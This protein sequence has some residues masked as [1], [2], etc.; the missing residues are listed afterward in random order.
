MAPVVAPAVTPA[1]VGQTTVTGLISDP[2]GNPATGG[3]VTFVLSPS[4]SAIAFR[5]AGTSIFAPRAVVCQI[6]PTGQLL[7][8]QGTGPCL[9][10]GN[11]A[12]L[13]GNTTYT[14]LIAPTVNGSPLTTSTIYGVLIFGS[15]YD[16]SNI[17]FAPNI[18]ITP[19]QTVLRGDPVEANLIPITGHV[20]NIGSQQLPYAALY[21]DDL[22]V[23]AGGEI[24]ADNIEA[25]NIAADN[26]TTS[27][28]AATNISTSQIRA[29]TYLNLPP[30]SGT[31]TNLL[32]AFYVNACNFTGP[33]AGSIM[34]S[35]IA[36]IPASGG[37][38]DARCLS[39]NINVT[40]TVP[41][42]V[43]VLLGPSY[44]A[45]VQ[46]FSLVG[47]GAALVGFGSGQDGV[48][49]DI[50]PTAP[51][52][53]SASG[54]A[55]TVDMIRVA[56][57]NRSTGIGAKL[58][59]IVLK[60]FAID[61]AG[62]GRRAVYATTT[63]FSIFEDIKIWN[64]VE[65]GFRLEGRLSTDP[66]S[67]PAAYQN[68]LHLVQVQ[69][70]ASNNSGAG[71][72]LDATNGEIS[73]TMFLQCRSSGNISTGGGKQALLL[74]AGTAAN[75]S[76]THTD[77]DT[78]YFGNPVSVAGSYGIQMKAPGVFTSQTGG[79]VWN[80]NIRATLVERL[81][82]SALGVGIGATDG[83]NNPSG[84]GVGST[85]L[86]NTGVGANWATAID[87]RN[88][89][90]MSLVLPN[91]SLPTN[92]PAIWLPSSNAGNNASGMT[93]DG[94]YSGGSPMF[95]LLVSPSFSG[96]AVGYGI[97]CSAS[98]ATTSYGLRVAGGITRFDGNVG[99]GEDPGNSPLRI[100]TAVSGLNADFLRVDGIATSTAA[101]QDQFAL[102]IV[103]TFATA[104]LNPG[105]LRGIL[106]DVGGAI[107][108][109][110]TASA[111]I[112]GDFTGP[113]AGA[114]LMLGVR[115]N[116]GIQMVP[117]V[118]K[119]TASATYRG[120]FWVTQGAAGVKDNVEVCAKD[121]TDTYAW[122]TIY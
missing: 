113:T 97:F 24:V 83:S 95:G 80:T 44:T 86:N 73:Y 54:F 36:T 11:P 43:T 12:I 71:I 60:G 93:I 99:L 108:G 109:G 75:A 74:E 65:D 120:T 10:W 72:H 45:T 17:Q 78:C 35:A 39:G 56:S 88:L 66:V 15:T 50:T 90:A 110:G 42:A 5:V 2:G 89:G 106:V 76:I 27:N 59:G 112:A 53:I 63:D 107:S 13:P 103:P 122:R 49:V 29:T 116:G 20:F 7:N 102:Q 9:I 121:A 14:L 41:R 21:V 46:A 25:K 55:S 52:I 22:N 34:N 92:G 6:S 77:I 85:L 61:M 64:G 84:V 98:G 26:I 114:S 57:T 31:I 82:S 40:V 16:L 38:C 4:S 101:G 94:T 69:P 117:N 79:R 58:V 32:G 51:T 70:L 81:F 1:A 115:S 18:E 91:D 62:V 118:A 23:S 96:A 48:G 100:G 67:G 104:G 28:L 3:T 37:I 19:Q 30:F 68:Y 8:E 111:G 119:P 33:D 87:Y 47:N 105:Q